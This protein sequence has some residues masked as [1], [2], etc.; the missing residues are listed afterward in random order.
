VLSR[1]GLRAHSSSMHVKPRLRARRSKTAPSTVY[2]FGQSQSLRFCLVALWLA[3]ATFSAYLL[4]TRPV[5]DSYRWFAGFCLLV[6]LAAAYWG[7]V[8]TQTGFVRWDGADWWVESSSA[9]IASPPRLVDGLTVQFDFQFFLLIRLD[10]AGGGSQWLWLDS[11][12]QRRDWHA[13][14]RAVFSPKP[15]PEPLPEASA[16]VVAPP[17]PAP[18]SGG[19]A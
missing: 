1:F 19:K 9:A 2:P 13:L 16:L 15:P 5:H 12:S 10:S 6:G 17:E 3:G 7:W 18:T 11:W 4:L 8:R 14:R